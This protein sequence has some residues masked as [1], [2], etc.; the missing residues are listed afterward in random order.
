[1]RSLFQPPFKGRRGCRIV[2]SLLGRLRVRDLTYSFC[3]VFSKIFN[4][5]SFILPFFTR[6]VNTVTVS[7]GGY[8]LSRSQNDKTSNI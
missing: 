5:E 4:P 7:E 6:K 2:S 1:M 3:R 8:T